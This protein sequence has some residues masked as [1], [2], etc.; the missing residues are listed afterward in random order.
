MGVAGSFSPDGTKL[1]VNRKAQS[2][3]R[4]Y[5]RGAYQS[6]VTVM[7]LAAKT[8]KDVTSFDGPLETMRVT[9]GA[10]REARR[11]PA[12]QSQNG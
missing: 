8:F 7:D 3:W 11:K 5:Y 1:A 9:V 2:Y 4:K 12:Q 10:V 6:D